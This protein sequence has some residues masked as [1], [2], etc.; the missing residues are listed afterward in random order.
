M[1]TLSFSVV[2]CTLNRCESLSKTLEAA[3][4]LQGDNFEIIVVNGPSEDET[5]KLL[6]KYK[7]R[8]K[9]LHNPIANVSKSRQIALLNS[10]GDIIVSLDDDVIPP[11]DW[12]LKLG[13]VYQREGD[14]CGAVGGIILDKTKGSHVVQYAYGS[15]TLIGE[16]KVLKDKESL[17]LSG[18]DKGWFPMLMGANASY[19]REALIKIGGFDEFFEYFLEETDVCLRLIQAG[20]QIHYTDVTVEHY[21]GQSHNRIDQIH[22]TCWHSLAKNST[23]FALKHGFKKIPFPLLVIR[24]TKVLI[25]RCFLRIL[26]LKLT[27]NL[28][29]SVLSSY[30]Q[31]AIEGIRVGWNAGISL[32]SEKLETATA[33]IELVRAADIA[34]FEEKYIQKHQIKTMQVKAL[35]NKGAYMLAINQQI[36]T[37]LNLHPIY[38]QVVK[39]ADGSEVNLEIVGP[40][41]V[42]F[43]NR[44]VNMDAF[45]LPGNSQ[46]LLG[47]MLFANME[48]VIN[49]YPE[50]LLV[51]CIANV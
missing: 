38:E 12:L 5:H 10:T 26:R 29:N 24:L 21:P 27:H 15:T 51:N 13:E 18:T 39:L 44:R 36:K 35:L 49:T 4:N 8:I 2:I 28:S 37:Q 11:P 31:Q 48:E 45:V 30:I 16:Q 33:E 6:A 42:R 7:N 47:D 1:N 41:E 34:L 20:Y 46:V 40:I 32:H 25:R 14:L 3:I 19:R 23:Y 9:I 50:N 22:L 43:A 17:L